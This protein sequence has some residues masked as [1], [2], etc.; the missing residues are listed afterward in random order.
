MSNK[1]DSKEL[2]LPTIRTAGLTCL[3][4]LFLL[5]SWRAGR[6]GLGSLLA[7][8]AAK[9]NQITAANAAVNLD[10]AS[11]DSHYVRATILAASDL[12]AAIDE[13][14]QAVLGRP[15]DYVLWLS[16][17]RARE[18]NGEPAGAVAAARQAV[19]LAPYYAGPRYQLGNILL[20][21][22]RKDEAFKEL[23][24]AGASNP[25]LM[26]GIIDLAWRLSGGDVQFVRQAIEPGTPEGYQALGQYFRAHKEVDAAIAM[27]AAAGSAAQQDRLSYLG[28]LIAAKRFK[29][30]AALWAVGRQAVAA[31]GVMVDP[32]FER[33]SDLT[34]PGF[35]WR[36][37][38]RPQ[39]FHLSLDTASPREGHSS[40]KVEF[41]G[42]PDPGSP[43][44]TQLVMIEPHAH[45]RLRFAVRSE[46]IVSGGLQRVV[47][48]DAN[49]S[50]ALG[51]SG[52]LP[53][54]TDG[55]RDYAIEFDSGPS[56]SAVQIALQRERCDRSPCPIF[57]RLWL[58]NFS[59]SKL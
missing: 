47:I 27:Y 25:T 16:L 37:G 6:S 59:L 57:G 51:Q 11:P 5:L 28:E 9:S 38:E 22:G 7:A 3:L 17:A 14:H 42:D 45:Y 35:A 39:G 40:L 1:S 48:V 10:A 4:V 15:D 8:Y 44:I 58:D 56:A 46:S 19:P 31:P 20:R 12:P 53:R 36:L 52:E 29:E 13:Y 2:P 54:A 21:A 24:L 49:T 23:R 34:E 55:W 32:G 30:A 18:L 41:N 50:S 26:P 33:E 43:I